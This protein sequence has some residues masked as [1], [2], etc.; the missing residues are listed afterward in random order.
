VLTKLTK[1]YISIALCC[2]KCNKDMA[3]DREGG[4]DGY[5]YFKCEAC[6]DEILLEVLPLHPS[7]VKEL[8]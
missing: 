3:F 7:K 6:G 2:V 8:K 5:S 1:T 4:E